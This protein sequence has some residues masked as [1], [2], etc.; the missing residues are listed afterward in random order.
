MSKTKTFDKILVIIE[1]FIFAFISALIIT[2]IF[3]WCPVCNKH[4][5]SPVIET[6]IVFLLLLVLSKTEMSQILGHYKSIFLF[7]FIFTCIENFEYYLAYKL[8]M[9][10]VEGYTLADIIS[11]K[12]LLAG[13]FLYSTPFWI[14]TILIMGWGLKKDRGIILPIL[15]L[16][17]AISLH[18]LFNIFMLNFT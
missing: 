11:L 12:E 7:S 5:L 6:I 16:I 3:Y 10:V 18:Y 17:I 13:R 4:S 2:G 1:I 8:G 15:C 14:I 9:G